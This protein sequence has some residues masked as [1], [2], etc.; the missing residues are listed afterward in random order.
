MSTAREE[1]PWLT[2]RRD[3]VERLDRLAS[4]VDKLSDDPLGLA[5][6]L[7]KT[8]TYVNAIAN[9]DASATGPRTSGVG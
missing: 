6:A 2:I 3:D 7:R 4:I 9:V 8:P 1:M 5:A